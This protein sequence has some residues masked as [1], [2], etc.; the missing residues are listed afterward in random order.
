[1]NSQNLKDILWI[2][3]ALLLCS[4]NSF[5]STNV[6]FLKR[7]SV[8]NTE[9]NIISEHRDQVSA[10]P[11]VDISC[12]PAY[13][14]SC[15][16]SFHPNST[17]WPIADGNEISPDYLCYHAIYSDNNIN[18]CG[19]GVNIVRTWTI[20]N[21]CGDPPTQCTQI[22]QLLDNEAPQLTC[23]NDFEVSCGDLDLEDLAPMPDVFDACGSGVSY[24]FQSSGSGDC[25][26][27]IGEHT[28]TWTVTDECGNASS[29]S[30][31]IEVVCKPTVQANSIF[32][33]QV[34]S[35]QM[36][37]DW[38]NGNGSH[39]IVKINT[40]NSFTAPI[41][42]SDPPADSH[43]GLLSGEKV[44]F[45]GMQD[46]MIVTGLSANTTYWFRIYEANECEGTISYNS[47][48]A[49]GNPKSQVTSGGVGPTLGNLTLTNVILNHL[50]FP[51]QFTLYSGP[52]NATNNPLKVCAD[53]TTATYIKLNVTPNQNIN[54]QLIDQSGNIVADA[55]NQVS[56]NPEVNGKFGLPNVFGNNIEISYTHPQFMDAIGSTHR[57]LTLKILYNNIP[58]SGISFPVQL[59]RAPILFVHGLWGAGS[60]FEKMANNFKNVKAQELALMLRINYT[61]NNGGSRSFDY[62]RTVIPTG[63]DDLFRQIRMSKFSAS[64]VDI[65]AHSMGGV[66]SRAYLQETSEYGVYRNDINKL[67]SIDSPF[68]GTQSANFLLNSYNWGIRHILSLPPLRNYC[69]LGAVADL[70]ANSP[71]IADLQNT[72]NNHHDVPIYPIN[73]TVDFDVAN[74]NDGNWDKMLLYV[75]YWYNPLLYLLEGIHNA[76]QLGKYVYF[77]EVGDLVVPKSSQIGGVPLTNNPPYTAVHTESKD[78]LSVINFVKIKLSE[79]PNN[80]DNFHANGYGNLPQME[81]RNTSIVPDDY[82]LIST[83]PLED[84]VKITTPTT[85]SILNPGDSILISATG[86]NGIIS[87]LILGGSE[88]SIYDYDSRDSN[89]IETYLHAPEEFAG[90]IL[91]Y[92]VGRDSN[93]IIYEDSVTV[94]SNPIAILD[95]IKIYPSTIQVGTGFSSSFDI[96]GYYNDGIVRNI[97]YLSGINYA[98]SDTN[99]AKYSGDNEVEGIIVG[100]SQL[101]VSFQGKSDSVGVNVYQRTDFGAA[102][103]N[104]ANNLVCQG[105]ELQFQN[106]SSGDPDSIGWVFQGG[107]PSTSNDQNPIVRYDTSGHFYLQLI[108]FYPTYS[109]TFLVPDYIDVIANPSATISASSATEFCQGDSVVLNVNMSSHYLWNT[110]ESSGE[111]VVSSEGLYSV[112]IADEY[113][114][115][116]VSDPVMI[117]VYSIPIPSIVPNGPTTYCYGDQVVLT[118]ELYNSILWSTGEPTQSIVVSNSGDY[119][120]AVIDS[121][122]CTGYSI[123]LNVLELD[124]ISALVSS[125]GQSS[126]CSGDSII[127][128]SNEWASYSWNTGDTS[129]SIIVLISG[130]YFVAVTDTNGCSGVSNP[131]NITVYDLPIVNLGPDTLVM[132]LFPLDAGNPGSSYEWNTGETSQ[133]ILV[134]STGWHTV[135]V[136]DSQ[137]CKSFDSVY[138]AIL[139]SIISLSESMQVKIYPNPNNGS[140]TISGE[141]PNSQE[142]QIKVIDPVGHTIYSSDSETVSGRFNMTI[143]LVNPAAGMYYLNLSVGDS[144]YSAKVII[145]RY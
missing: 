65:V 130:D 61:H 47:E 94:F 55:V 133:T 87:M 5:A 72:S 71:A 129:Q 20:T 88:N 84:S 141:L 102:A 98:I 2:H 112:T 57:S 11:L 108:A 93:G 33:S 91:V 96:N 30:F 1:M 123:P 10:S 140:F 124:S 50:W 79:N 9:L 132:S 78:D 6:S 126:F 111:I 51:E 103:M 49:I 125:T 128:N 3:F 48:L 85:N 80:P 95:S 42:G 97:K 45:N 70:R 69:N 115:I 34:T 116:G 59:Y 63:I 142:L 122:G 44:I 15:G 46:N 73:T 60:S 77:N 143:D 52:A 109:D 110:G 81:I 138:V 106:T 35:T 23:P 27:G 4:L 17:G 43:Y 145:Q 41:E 121:N 117:T 53:G 137:G 76:E 54:F 62:N 26:G 113:G 131:L 56:V 39:R 135:T 105:G 90:P 18:E 24:S 31:I 8:F 32:F 139:T 22:I 21:T 29:C 13:E 19:N 114:C 107:I 144:S 25:F 67:V 28:C 134:D 101:S 89:A 120:V 119:Y 68:N 7:V 16:E 58:I 86:T 14:G 75:S 40:S 92:C 104:V 136:T 74:Y 36:E 37:L 118:T 100:F 38:S 127:L 12:P 83:N 66:L 82:G 99:I 64:K